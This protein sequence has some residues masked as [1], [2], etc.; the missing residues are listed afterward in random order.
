MPA[1]P[2]Q[3]VT[4]LIVQILAETLGLE[5]A[6]LDPN[7]RFSRYGL[8]SRLAA[9]LIARLA[10]ELDRPLPATLVWDH[11]T[12]TRLA[13]FLA[14][15]AD[16]QETA[17]IRRLPDAEPIAIIA[18]AC[19]LPGA[20]DPEAFWRLL[21][22]GVDA[23]GPIPD[24]RWNVAELY[25]PDP[26]A[27]GRMATRWGG[28]LDQVDRFDAEFFGISPR[29]ALEIDPQ[30]RLV[31]EL[32]WEAL[33]RAAITPSRLAGSRTGVFMGA[34]WSEYGQ[35]AAG[36]NAIA[37]HSATGRD[38]AIIANRVSYLLG[39][40]GP[41][42]TVNT[43]CS[44][45][46]AA[47]HL[48]CQSLR[49]GESTL[50]LAGGVNLMLT[51]DSTVAMT[52]FG[53]MAPDG[54]SK[55]F[56]ARAN[57]YV[58][59]EGAGV[60]LL[61][62]LAQALADGDP[63][64]AVV[65]GSAVNNDGPSNGLTAP[66]PDAQRAV[67]R[68]AYARARVSPAEVDYVEAHGTGTLLGDP[69]EAGSLGTV[70][71]AARGP[72]RPLIIGSAK[73]NI[74][75]LEAAAG[76]AGLIKVSMALHY[77]VIPPSL[78]FLSPNPNIDFA[79]LNLRVPT[80]PEPWPTTGR[81]G[82]AGVSSFGFG[83]TNAHAVLEEWRVEAVEPP[84]RCAPPLLSQGGEFRIATDQRRPLIFVYSGNG[85][86]WLGMGRDL[87]AAEP[88]FR[89]SVEACDAVFRTLTED[90]SILDELIADARWSRLADTV[91]AQ[92]LMFAVQIGLTRLLASWGYA[93][94]AVVGHSLGEVAA[95]CAA[96]VLSLEDAARVV[97]H[98]SRLQTEA[99]GQGAMAQIDLTW[100]EAE[101]ALAAH[102]QVVIAGA[103]APTAVTISGPA[104]AVDTVMAELAAHGVNSQRIRVD[105]AYHSP[106]MELPRQRL[107]EALAGLQPRFGDI[108][109]Y[110]T[111]AGDLWPG[112]A[113]DADYW[114][115]NLREPV[116]FAQAVAALPDGVV[117]E[118]SP[119][120]IL[121]RS[122]E[123]G[124]AARGIAG[125]ALFTLS[126]DETA[127]ESLHRLLDRLTESG[128]MAGEAPPDRP[129]HLL[130]LS[131]RNAES[132][133]D[134]AGRY[135][136]ALPDALAD[137]C[138]TANTCREAFSERAALIAAT[139]DEMREQL[140]VLAG[141]L[142]L[143]ATIYRGQARPGHVPPV[144]FQF[145]D[146]RPEFTGLDE[147]HDTQPAFAD[148]LAALI[149]LFMDE[150]GL[151]LTEWFTRSVPNQITLDSALT[152]GLQLAMGRLW[153]SW[154]I[155]PAL[156]QGEGAGYFTAEALAG[157]LSD[158]EAL[159]RT[160]KGDWPES[161]LEPPS[162][163]ALVVRWGDGEV[164]RVL[165]GILGRL[166]VSGAAIDWRAVDRPY[167]RRRV[168][169]PTYPFQRVRYWPT[170]AVPK[171]VE[172]WLYELAWAPA[173]P[174]R[175]DLPDP[176][177]V[178]AALPVSTP[179]VDQAVALP[180]ML[181]RLAAAYAAQALAIMPEPAA[182]PAFRSRQWAALA[183][184]AAQATDSSPAVL[185]RE[186][187]A[188]YPAGAAE[189]ALIRRTGEALPE[190]LA[191]R[192]DPLQVLFPDGSMDWVQPVYERAPFARTTV[193]WV[194]AIFATVA[195][196]LGSIIEIGAG[197]GGATSRVL[198]SLPDSG[199]YV[200]TDVSPAFLE[201]AQQRFSGHPGFATA[202]LDIER[203]PDEQSVTE[204]F[205]AAL[206]VN[207]LHA[208]RDVR[209]TLAHVRGLLRH[210]GWLALVEVTGEPG[211]LDLVFGMLEG[212]WRFADTDLRDSSA[213]L[214]VE[215]WRDL[216]AEAGF[217]AV[218]T[219]FDGDRQNVILARAGVVPG[220]RLVLGDAC[221][222][223]D[224][225]ERL[226]AAG[227]PVEV[228]DAV[229]TA[230]VWRE[231]VV[232]DQE[233]TPVEAC[234]RL[235]ML[236][237]DPRF[238]RVRLVEDSNHPGA[239][240]HPSLSKEGNKSDETSAAVVRAV[241]RGWALAAGLADPVRW[242]GTL[243]GSDLE[244][245]VGALLARS[246]EELLDI[247]ID[248]VEP[249]GLRLRPLSALDNGLPVRGEGTYLITGGLGALGLNFARWLV[250]KGARYLALV[251][252]RPPTDA[253]AGVIATLEA[254]GIRVWTFAAN[255][256]DLAAMQGVM[257][258]LA[259]QAPPL[260]GVIH[261]AGIATD[262]PVEALAVKLDGAR[263]LHTVTAEA[264]P[265]LFL[266]F[267]SAAGVWGAKGKEA[268]AAANAGLDAF[269]AERRRQGLP[270]LSIAWGRF[271]ERGLLSV[272][273]DAALAE[274]GL[275]AMT[276]EL[277]FD[278]AWRLTGS[279]RSQ[280]VIAHVDWPRFRSVYEARGRRPLL[281]ELPRSAITPTPARPRL[282]PAPLAGESGESVFDQV[283]RLVAETLGHADPETVAPDRGL[284]ELGLDSLMAVRLRRRLEE[285]L[286]RPIPAA[287]LFS[288]PTVAALAEWLTPSTTLR[289]ADAAV[290]SPA[291]NDEPIAVIGI[292]C[293]FPG[294]VVDP[295][296]FARLL[297]EGHDAVTELPLTRWDWR[298]WFSENPDAPGYMVSRWGG[299]LEDIDQFDAAFFN[300][301]P[302]EAAYMDPQQRLL[303]EVAREAVERAGLDPERLT[304]MRAGVFIGITG[305]DYATLAR[306]GPPEHLEAQAITGQPLNTAAGR[307]A[308]ALG[309]TG[310]AIALDTAC[311]SSLVALHLACRA[312]RSGEC[313]LALAGGVNL[314]LA[315]E[316][317]VI[318]SRAGMLSPTG[319]C[320]T[321]DA[322]ADGF[323]RAEGCGMV[324]LKP[325]SAALADGDPVLAV[326]RGTAMN[327]DGR[328][329]GFTVPNGSAQEQVIRTALADAGFAPAQISYIEA[330]GTGTALGDPIEVQALA[331]AFGENRATP[332]YV[333]SVKTNIGHAESA[334][335]IAAFIKTVLALGA[336][337]IPANQ[338]FDRLNPHIH[339][340]GFPLVIPT[341]PIP[342]PMMD[343]RRIAGVSSFGASGTNVH[344]IVE[345]PPTNKTPS[346]LAGE[347]W[348]GGKITHILPLS[349]RDPE[350]LAALALATAAQLDDDRI[351]DLAFS[352][353]VSRSSLPVRGFA[354]FN[355]AAEGQ[356]ALAAATPITAGS[357][358]KVAFLFTGQGAQ[359]AGMAR[360][361]YQAE[362]VFRAFID[363]C[364]ALASPL[365]GRSLQETM[366]DPAT[367][368]DLDATALAQPALFSLGCALAALWRSWGVEPAAVLGHSVGEYAAA[369][370]AG[371][372]ELETA[373]PLIITRGRLMQAL[374]AGGGMRAVL[375]PVAVVT[376][377]LAEEPTLSIAAI[378]GPA[379]T[380][381]SGSLAALER[382]SVRLAAE[383]LIVRPL[384][385]SHAFHSALLD[386]MLEAL[387]I[388]AAR[389]AWQSAQIPLISNLTGAPQATFDAAYWRRHAREPVQFAKSLQ[390]AAALGCRV[391]IEMGPQPVL[392]GLAGSVLDDA[393]LLPGLRRDADDHRTLYEALGRAWQAGV[394]VD[395][396]RVPPN[397][398][399]RRLALPTTPFRHKRHWL[400]WIDTRRQRDVARDPSA[401]WVYQI[402]WEAARSL[403][404]LAG[405][406]SGARVWPI[407][408]D[409][410]PDTLAARCEELK[411]CV[412]SAETPI[413]VVTRGAQPVGM[414]EIINPASAALWGLG[415]I[416]ALTHPE[417]WGGLID[418]DP[419]AD[420]A[421]NQAMLA[422]FLAD[423][424]GEDQVALRD[425]Q[426]YAPRLERLKTPLPEPRPIHP[427]RTCLITG[428]LGGLGLALAN[429]L[430]TAGARY[431][432][433]IGRRPPS[434]EAATVIAGLESR[435]VTVTVF[436]AD[437][438]DA[439]GMA[440]VA[441]R[442]AETL[443]PVTAIFHAAGVKDGDFATVLRPKLTGAQVLHEISRHWPV[444]QFVLFSSAAAVWGDRHLEAYAVAN[445]ALDGF[446]HW[447]WAQELPALSV[448]W[449]RFDARGMLDSAGAAFF[450]RMGLDPLPTDPAFTIMQRLAA[451]ALPQATVAAVRW[452]VFK[453]IYE[454]QR[455]R[456]LLAC[457][458]PAPSAV[459]AA[460]A[461]TEQP[462]AVKKLSPPAVL[463][464]LRELVAE[465]LGLDDPNELDAGR[466]FFTLGMDS[467]GV[468]DLRRRVEAEFGVALPAAALFEAPSIAALASR[469]APEP[470]SP[471]TPNPSPTRGEGSR[472]AA[473]AEPIA[474]IGLGL[475]LPGEVH[476]L[477]GLERLL[478]AGI[479]AV[480]DRPEERWT[481][482]LS[483]DPARRRSGFLTGIDRFDADFFG[484]SPREAA[485][486][487]PQHRL[488]L[489]VAWEALQHAGWSPPALAGSRIGVFVG[490]T[491]AEY[492]ALAAARGR[493]DAHAVGGQF[494]NV[495][496]GRISHTLGLTG[497]SLAVDT[498]C[499]SSAM[500]VHL[501]CQALRAGECD[502]ALAG[503]VNLLLA[504]ETTE[505]LIQARMLA[506][507]G[508]CKTF[509]AAA[510]GYVRAEGCGLVVLKP[511][512]Q[513]EADG[514]RVL[515]VIRGT[516]ANHDGASSGFTVPNGAAQEAVMRAALTQASIA[517]V[518]VS[519]VEAHGT[520]TALGDPVELHALDAVYGGGRTQPLWV[521]SIKT[522]IGHAEA[523]A[524][525]AGLLKLVASLHLQH[526]PPHLN[527]TR[528]NP[529]IQVSAERVAVAAT[530]APWEP[531]DGRRLAGLS[532]FGASGTNVHLIV[533]EPPSSPT[534]LSPAGE[535][536]GLLILSA[537]R[538]GDLDRLTEEVLAAPDWRQACREAA[539]TR[540]GLPH[541]LAVVATNV[542]ELRR[543]LATAPR[544]RAGQPRIAF[545]FTGQGSQ[546]PGMGRVL[547]E[548]EPVFREA[549][550]RCA[551]AAQGRLAWPLLSLLFD[552]TRPLVATEQVQPA[553]FALGYA[554][555][556]LWR[557]WGVEPVAVLGHSV[558]EITAACVAGAMSLEEALALIIERGRLMGALPAGGAMAAVLAPEADLAE[559]LVQ[560]DGRV[561][562][563]ARNGPANTVLSGD[564]AALEP[565][566]A[567]LA[568]QGIESRPLAVS[569]AFHSP[570]LDPML[571]DLERAAG[572]I[573]FQPTRI[574]VAANL[575]GQART[576]FDAAYWRAQARN[577]V[578]FAAG[579][580]TLAELGCD[581][582]IEIG[583]QPVLCG[584]G[585]TC[586]DSGVWIPSLRRGEAEPHT[587][588]EAAGTIW[589]LG[590][591]IHWRR[592]LQIAPR[593]SAPLPAYPFRRTRHWL[594]PSPERTTPPRTG[595]F[596]TRLDSPAFSGTVYSDRLGLEE[597]PGLADSGHLI[598]VGLHLAFLAAALNQ[599]NAG[600]VQ[601]DDAG[602]PRALRLGT[603]HDLQIVVQPDGHATLFAR[604]GD[605]S[606]IEHFQASVIADSPPQ[607]PAIH[608]ETLKNRCRQETTQ[609]DFYADLAVRGFP[610]GPRLRRIERLWS[611]P[612]EAVAH[613]SDPAADE[614]LAFG[615]PAALLEACAQLPIAACPELTGGYMLIGWRRLIRS[616]A[617]YRSGT[618]MHATASASADGSRLSADLTLCADDGEVFARIDGAILARVDPAALP[619]K[620]PQPASAWIGD[621]VWEPAP[622]TE[623]APVACRLIA[624]GPDT[625]ALAIRLTT[626]R[627]EL[628]GAV[629]TV[630]VILM[631][632]DPVAEPTVLAHVL[633]TLP[634]LPSGTRLLLISRG[635]WTPGAAVQAV[636]KGGAGLWGLAQAVRAE[637]ADLS[638]R[639]VDLDPD[640]DPLP[641][642]LAELADVSAETA[643]AWRNGQ[644]FVARLQPRRLLEP[645]VAPV[646]LTGSPISQVGRDEELGVRVC[647]LERRPPG[648]DEVEIT[649]IAAAPNFRDLLVIH[650]QFPPTPGLGADCSGLI[651]TLGPGVVDFAPGDPVIAYVP[652]GQGSLATHVTL[653]ARLVRP[654]PA[655]L[656]FAAA[657]VIPVAYLTAWHG[658]I[659]RAQLHPGETVLIHA[660]GSGVGWAAMA[661]A[662]WIG[663]QVF[664]TASPA[665]QADLIALGVPIIGSSRDGAFA[666]AAREATNGRG[667]DVAMGAFDRLAA[668]A[669][670][671]LAEGG[672]LIDLTRRGEP[673]EIDL[674]H[675]ATREPVA[676]AR[677]FDAVT[678]AL[679][680]GRLP[681]IPYQRAPWNEALQA[682]HRQIQ[683]CAIGRLCLRFAEEPPPAFTGTWL[684]TGAS[685]AIGAALAHH[686]AGC[687]V[688]YLVLLDRVA[689]PPERLQTLA[690]QGVAALS[691][692]LD[693]SDEAAMT[694]LFARLRDAF[695]PL[696]GI[697]HTAALT[698]D[699]PLV[700]L[701]AERF[702]RVFRPK[703]KGARLLDRLSR[704]LPIRVFALFSSVVS[705]LPSARQGA[706][707]AAN[708]A[709]D[710]LARQRR[711]LGLPATSIHWGPW[712]IGIGHSM[713]QRA[714]AVWDSWGV[715]PLTEAAGLALF[716]TLAGSEGD[717]VVLDIDWS[718]YLAQMDEPPP[719]L[720]G[721]REV[722]SGKRG[723]GSGKRET[724]PTLTPETL[725]ALIRDVIAR[726]LG[727]AEPA[728]IES[729]RPF[730]EQ[731]L[732]SLMATEL[733]AT[734]S[735]RLGVRLP[736]TLV[737]NYPTLDAL[738]AHLT[739]RLLPATP[740]P[741]LAT[742]RSEEA[743]PESDTADDL[744][745]QLEAKLASIDRLLEQDSD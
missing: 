291:R 495:A 401:D 479:E 642:L 415:R 399:H 483:A 420:P 500:A 94:D 346:P 392:T 528:L 390:S 727:H 394:A 662:R 90:W 412:E 177:V 533:E 488:L 376:P 631:E 318:L 253:A 476:D 416:L 741:A 143:R 671:A 104:A 400:D 89:A 404:P 418:L 650:G 520:G 279:E 407:D 464:R 63:V 624:T 254:S 405:E 11:P 622:V 424:H 569:H 260:A 375:T 590:A 535:G 456:P 322:G 259:E 144:I 393:V 436:A 26:E 228:A 560:T 264:T 347:S 200:F 547:Y 229:P 218:S 654:K 391:F 295:D 431:L 51:P 343:G 522:V 381:I 226:R 60:A 459:S 701:D 58:R 165:L 23:V 669:R 539:L 258:T 724:S 467:F 700:E 437:V 276:P 159:Q 594:E 43:A 167:P 688:R 233:E 598:H 86:Q 281:D 665:K 223:A 321:F 705:M 453:P 371:V 136:A 75:H 530:G 48:A 303:L 640:A 442:I 685:G 311:S 370:S 360:A 718:R 557:S 178:V 313:S 68:D 537:R 122:V 327:H 409:A 161:P 247:D 638:V 451:T 100:D 135:A 340:D 473:T 494:L 353:G 292:G 674:D 64:L 731:G 661:I 690:A 163:D 123:S 324:V 188:D 354:V 273:E 333:G 18:V 213:L 536:S 626:E 561:V 696:T 235:A 8:S 620:S 563:A 50:A 395:W 175:V 514:D 140:A 383:N 498:A 105:I 643:S 492:A 232:L 458:G 215:R 512:A 145:A 148:A 629:G 316:T 106:A 614:P 596:Q 306:R 34:M 191:G 421:Q 134:L 5:P 301:P 95:A 184:L 133:R 256:A 57:G 704:G 372:L 441:T 166:S 513:A 435:G 559:A 602:F 384:S 504:P 282:T 469:L 155:R 121:T 328:A 236:F 39:L 419:S 80:A 402:E 158:A 632:T 717:P 460:L 88:V 430:V 472:S 73:T 589:R 414:A 154:G 463:A 708:A 502:T 462:V 645:P 728:A 231:T 265:G 107:I 438:A 205:D 611:Q 339:L 181:D 112:R 15:D 297:F 358:V 369:V 600:P 389:I 581:A 446:A 465:I 132:L 179:S 448:N 599:V 730:S 398:P 351:A 182:G 164:W 617:P 187:A 302:K 637:R 573:T 608:P 636:A 582:F 242:G 503:G 113:F 261:A 576:R 1:N 588:L 2:G 6:S 174:F 656:S 206:A 567:E 251:G 422:A 285:A 577:P 427:D 124:L 572:R 607:L 429:Y 440:Q 681:P 604:A 120:P 77:R 317:S 269:A 720:A 439:E 658:L 79:R 331:A 612:G 14:G 330:H 69:I 592:V 628:F 192:V 653:P 377:F 584:L 434:E 151:L 162:S 531:V 411:R 610:L 359:Y 225:A 507:D 633:T 523:A 461:V 12:A 20:G 81:P 571:D 268:Y 443:P 368:A 433:L 378:N 323:V 241:R 263:I 156:I 204:V 583:P 248:G 689:P 349:A 289:M 646:R 212:W 702:E 310:P 613:L 406:R 454:G 663:A 129:V 62:P 493:P 379:N 725:P 703:V 326:V 44:S 356:A 352:A 668:S 667:V 521:G 619:G 543:K 444:E 664:A 556:E 32:V 403:L 565:V 687:G 508:R 76:I 141:G 397:G 312:L 616:A 160:L 735:A 319:R 548:R 56:D 737:Y 648:P 546:Y 345:A 739:T 525:I 216:L 9:G 715:Q 193:S 682:L 35:L 549:L 366:L 457:L 172:S 722:D 31:L 74:G 30:Q 117:V 197:T 716:D 185:A 283:R 257:A 655:S 108:L 545:L 468:V 365:L 142:E 675:L 445:A 644:R 432:V 329:S 65:R 501:A 729:D 733:A 672:R 471:L 425:G 570:R 102:P 344:L 363:R 408:M 262:D 250:E 221:F 66:S 587:L 554:L 670:E 209:T 84:R 538:A 695:P 19:R 198:P 176:D 125:P 361:L 332:L 686:L 350:S 499:S 641:A 713:G 742:N 82:L 562:I 714:E 485:Q 118:L 255:V 606:W 413:W 699:A 300:I 634:L 271:T 396:A 150:T 238:G 491:G 25:D 70:L 666:A 275:E 678:N 710:H 203:S 293:R 299:F 169:L 227:V 527:F 477:A 71:G 673:G 85:A 152:F 237:A 190:V 194:E 153:L 87:L 721:L 478:L 98:R 126:R 706:Y 83:G 97:F 195:P 734:L 201:R 336:E 138:Y 428:G 131:A 52:K 382:L 288:H 127:A 315:P 224:L 555:A 219:L 42:L 41:S 726:I 240:R 635:V 116:R 186:I 67:L 208:T 249:Q 707:A 29:E 541:R 101:A 38:T 252:R 466:G 207:V 698:D 534:P 680:E 647:P 284:F 743:L 423:P 505:M 307:I 738:V 732:D 579:M 487:D 519:Y 574:P 59:G 119:H 496:A 712:A 586:L 171:P 625:E 111:V 511:L 222:A 475:R 516:A 455:P 49:E 736:G 623:P 47:L 380:V 679:T 78:H 45:S 677:L 692:T 447:R 109:I 55:A 693:I 566:L 691:E 526:I 149:P 28:F 245:I 627:P 490:I 580:A 334:A 196:Q 27:P 609:Q 518:N 744:L 210:G 110:S 72:E 652:N 542:D 22:N 362:P 294:G 558:G 21:L 595:W 524:G 3:T 147:L 683:G 290:A 309:L 426:A 91:V 246:D 305:N 36:L 552:T 388:E 506:A 92:S 130:T 180:T 7:E 24:D 480:A 481:G 723:A 286:G 287:A 605:G 99:A 53:A 217:D 234:Q 450:D 621:L 244:R 615:L 202:R 103:N 410:A 4:A 128:V 367:G 551:E 568:K 211:W 550:D 630:V 230:G 482:S 16:A 96:G 564:E 540:D 515:A 298:E 277:A 348:G 220:Q 486:I 357:R 386:P 199:R 639:S 373:L 694:A 274:M 61:K 173:A 660:A 709:L 449:G 489:E 649:V 585:R 46:L 697:V 510:D 529:Q 10:A 115:W 553:L 452:P 593:D 597:V 474:I 40:T 601:I 355:N 509:D 114:G 296:G 651:A 544:S 168:L 13:R 214:P 54:R 320:R 657:A 591:K 272:A 711:T 157:R 270:A 684:I 745:N 314:V 335:G 304:G 37:Q 338:H 719:W 532:A 575:D 33:E 325:L 266:L 417:R 137:A 364:D 659:E 337:R 342:W 578:A 603:P 374:P 385:V 267:S 170:P 183:K 308:F 497:P 93:P 280:A 676:F 618:W 17:A 243:R 239:S 740:L 278:L 146:D 484:I 387:E 139:A 189:L 517:P 341:A 470:A